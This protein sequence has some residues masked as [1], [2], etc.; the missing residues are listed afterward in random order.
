MFGLVIIVFQFLALVFIGGFT[1]STTAITNYESFTKNCLFML[2]LVMICAPYKKLSV[3]AI[4]V[5]IIG[6]TIAFEMELLMGRFWEHA[7]DGFVTEFQLTARI[8]V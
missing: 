8:L 5:M 7:F 1:R 4:M 2:C 3:H 6:I